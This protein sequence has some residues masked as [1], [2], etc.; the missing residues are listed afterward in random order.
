MSRDWN[1][2]LRNLRQGAHV[3]ILLH[4]LNGNPGIK[5]PLQ[6][7]S[8]ESKSNVKERGTRD[9]DQY[10]IETLVFQNWRS[11][12]TKS[13]WTC[14][15]ATHSGS[16]A[17]PR[18]WISSTFSSR[19]PLFAVRRDIFKLDKQLIDKKSMWFSPMCVHTMISD[20]KTGSWSRNVECHNLKVEMCFDYWTIFSE[21][22]P[23]V[24]RRSRW[25]CHCCLFYTKIFYESRMNQYLS[26]IKTCMIH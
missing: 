7:S 17:E 23:F 6:I 22:W 3:G 21:N 13:K 10:T 1:R 5:V 4:D 11:P 15:W 18:A 24:V 12:S 26:S 20:D 19:R 25:N 2:P 8:F 9:I 16:R 14:T